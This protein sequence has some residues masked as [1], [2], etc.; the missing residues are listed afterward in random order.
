[1]R[2][3]H[4]NRLEALASE[5]ARLIASDPAEPLTPERIVVPH[6]TMARWLKLE[7]AR[8]LGIAANLRFEQPAAFAWSILRGAVPSLSTE[9]GFSPDTLRWHIF[10]QLPDF[11]RGADAA[12]VRR[13]LADGD[14]RKR[15]ELADKLAGVFDRCINFRDDWIRDW[16][17]GAAPHWQARLWQLLAG[18]V[19][20]RHWVH[21][22]DA[23]ERELA[24]GLEPKNWPRRVFVFGVSALSPSY[25]RLL[26]QLAA[27]I[28]LHVF[29]F[30]PSSEYWS[31]LRTEREIRYRVED[32]DANEQYF[33][34]GN[35]LLAAWGRA[36]RFTFE[37]L[38]A[39]EVEEQ[40]FFPP[41]DTESRLAAV[42]A[43]IQE[44]RD[45]ADAG[46]SD[47]VAPD[48]SLQIHCCHSPMREAE[49][50]HDRLLDLLEKNSDIEP[51]DIMI[52]TPN[53]ARYGPV[54]AAVFEAE[55]R[56]PVDLSRFQAADSSTARAF[57]DLLSLP[58]TRY[59]V[60]A[61][62]APLD[63]PSLRARFGIDE[64]SL[65]AI[66]DWVRQ[67]GIRRGVAPD[68][69]E[70]APAMPGNTWNEGLQRLLMGYAAGDTDDLALGVAPC[71]IR[72]EGG[73]EA[74]EEDYETLGRFITYCTAAIEL[75]NDA[76]RPRNANQ[77]TISLRRMLE[78]FFDNG[79]IRGA[80]RGFEGVRAAAGEFEEVTS[81]IDNFATQAGRI[82][83]PI[84]FEV[85]RQTLREAA[86]GP[87]IE[88]AQLADGATI[89][90]L[91]PGQVL[92][93][94]IVC[95]VGMNGDGFPRNPPRHT[96]DPVE[97]DKRRA[98]DRDI[99][100]ED[101]FAFLEALLAARN[102]FIVTYTGRDQRDD[103]DIP[104]S[105]LVE[106]LADSLAV[107]FPDS[108]RFNHPLQPFS[109]RYF[110]GKNGLFS[111]SQTMLDAAGVLHSRDRQ[112][113]DRFANRLP[114]PEASRRKVSL[115]ELERYF[116][117][118]ARG[119]L[120][121]RFG[122]RL[123][124]EEKAIE[125]VEPLQ[126]DGLQRWGLREEILNRTDAGRERR[127]APESVRSLLLAN[128]SLPYG[129]FGAL[130]CDEAFEAANELRQLLAPHA[131]TLA[132]EP[133]PF[134][135][136]IGDFRLTGAIPHVGRERM[137]WWRNGKQN[138]GDL[139]QIRLRQLAWVAAGNSPLP[140]T[141]IWL[142]K[143]EEF[144]APRPQTESIIHWL[145]AWWRGLSQPL[146]FFPESSVAYARELKEGKG[147]AE[148]AMS[149]ARNTW[150]GDSWGS[151]PA[152]RDK[153]HNRLVW[154]LGEDEDPLDEDFAG[155][156]ELLLSPMFGEKPQ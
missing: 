78:R 54:I 30:N 37:S 85:V 77:W 97:R 156:A 4:S 98:G 120:R 110:T 91:A 104:P 10:E 150:Q 135:L 143:Q 25:L 130:A 93:A 126:L 84:S 155:L 111:Y 101:R 151:A 32:G 14:E 99:R 6:Q 153:L 124:E 107:R 11:A 63:A 136:E 128:G 64:N 68:D 36:G 71:S 19:P 60:E 20:E 103:S 95:A 67:A 33:E 106:E 89:G 22:L 116:T 27:S 5:M 109:T 141:A 8:E 55:G 134:R 147:G 94:R 79:S 23:F 59:G 138:P 50:L 115:E 3:Y 34:E 154:D 108:F 57:F 105:V 24:G 87:A 145:E 149:M 52:L 9:Q 46:G 83:C 144:A 40:S 82:D 7:L 76:A 73:F 114:E 148:S 16:E 118:P 88:P 42:Q 100:H 29:L 21:A 17:Q 125:E 39:L 41:P 127:A 152:E 61:V 132:A 58:G 31:D 53:L 121:E 45:S 119:F 74:G 51:A 48:D 69:G 133:V 139:V 44:V 49:A 18:K 38:I 117:N 80:Y 66:R 75:R 90:R 2:V 129:S 13:F 35:K 86:T 102:A 15:F 131:E 113:P 47:V 122:I 81:L 140:M 96:F 123:G 62:L 12:E 142:G 112:S 1:M 26:K 70:Q 72:G 28:E 146:R 65:P 43:D 137:V 92:P 56:I